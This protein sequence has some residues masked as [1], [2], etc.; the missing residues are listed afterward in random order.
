ME[1]DA[2]AAAAASRDN[3]INHRSFDIAELLV[4]LEVG[5]ATAPILPLSKAEKAA[6]AASD[7]QRDEWDRYARFLVLDAR[8]KQG[9][10]NMFDLWVKV[11]GPRLFPGTAPAA[12]A[13]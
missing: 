1:A 3:K 5:Q 13:P 9:D 11:R 8:V 7:V 6:A 12:P 2:R 10:K 4:F